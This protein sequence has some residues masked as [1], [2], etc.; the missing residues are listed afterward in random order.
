MSQET[1]LEQTTPEQQLAAIHAMLSVGH[2]G[3]RF[4]RHTFVLWGIVSAFLMLVVPELF[5]HFPNR[6]H[7][8]FVELGLTSFVI[9]VGA[10]I[11]F[12]ITCRVRQRE[13]ETLPFI[14]RQILK[15]WI[16]LF[17][18]G[19][20]T[21]L[22]LCL[23]YGG[24]SIIF[25][26]WIL[27]LGI[28]LFTSGLFSD[29]FLRW[30]GVATIMIGAVTIIL[31]PL[32]LSGYYAYQWL[33]ISVFGLGLPALGL[34]LPRLNKWSQ[35]TRIAALLGWVLAVGVFAYSAFRVKRY[36]DRPKISA[37]A[38][39]EFQRQGSIG[40]E[41]VIT[42]PRGTVVPMRIAWRSNIFKSAPITI[43]LELTRSLDLVLTDGELGRQFRTE[44]EDWMMFPE[45]LSFA[46]SKESA[47]LTQSDGPVIDKFIQFS[48]GKKAVR[49]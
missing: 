26:L 25:P 37:I 19:V 38:F 12:R 5:S 44:G 16:L 28:G 48:A 23:Y 9:G 7:R 1:S 13:D 33:A 3:V 39:H 14:Q 43:P 2:R 36:I 31:F 40:R 35:L 4:E 27:L 8:A 29:S 18:L 32:R 20:M 15:V 46:G 11:D 10:L 17:G 34:L 49:P 45:G 24:G 21:E 47:T 22:G 30:V 41:Q 42:L 6:L